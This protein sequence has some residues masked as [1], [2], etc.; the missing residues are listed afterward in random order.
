MIMFKFN[1]LRDDGSTRDL[2]EFLVLVAGRDLIWSILEFDGVGVTPNGM[3]M[4]DF[5]DLVRSLPRGFILPW[6]DL[7]KFANSIHQTYDC[8]IAGA[9]SQSDID[10]EALENG[11]CSGAMFAVNAVDISFW[12]V[13]ADEE[14]FARY[15]G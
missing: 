14:C 13:W 12:N 11:D 9:R 15:S 1:A 3:D 2:R 7:L 5:S 10:R 6:D 4:N 8:L